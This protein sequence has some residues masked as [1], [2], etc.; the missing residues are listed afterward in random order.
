M[1]ALP[2]FI[3]KASY[4]YWASEA[5]YDHQVQSLRFTS[6]SWTVAGP[7]RLAVPCVRCAVPLPCVALRST[8][9]VR[10]SLA[11]ST[12]LTLSHSLLADP[13]VS[14]LSCTQVTPFRHLYQVDAISAPIWGYKLENYGTQSSRPI[15]FILACWTGGDCCC[16]ARICWACLLLCRHV[17][18]TLTRAA[19]THSHASRVR[20]CGAQAWTSP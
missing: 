17:V 5:M 10:A 19:L 18:R 6:Q 20:R 11:S 14:S 15:F 8:R 3:K 16:V 9:C 4:A 2:E 1:A 7:G 13:R 12:L